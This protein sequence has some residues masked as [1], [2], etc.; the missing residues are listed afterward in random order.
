MKNLIVIAL[1]ALFLFFPYSEDGMAQVRNNPNAL[2]GIEEIDVMVHRLD[3][4]LEGSG[5]TQEQI[6]A[7]M[8][9]K[10]GMAVIRVV[11]KAL[12]TLLLDIKSYVFPKHAGIVILA[13]KLDLYQFVDLPI[14]QQI[15]WTSTWSSE[16]LTVSDTPNITGLKELV[17]DLLNK[18]ITDFN[19][20]KPKK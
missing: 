6:K 14:S 8:E 16:S 19:S 18:F 10:L 7:E 2:R 20:V 13:V 17:A 9:S 11:P 12:P 15:L 5:Y 4:R 1:T 3:S